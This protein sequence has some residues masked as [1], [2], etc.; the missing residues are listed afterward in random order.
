M[1]LTLTVFLQL[2]TAELPPDD[3]MVGEARNAQ[4]RFERLRR[5]LLPLK[6][7]RSAAGHCDAIMGRI[8]YWYDSTDVA[9]EP[10]HPRVTAARRELLATLERVAPADSVDGWV[11]GQQI[12]YLLETG[13]WETAARVAERDCDAARWW[14]AA[15][16]GTALHVGQRYERAD[17]AFNSALREMSAHQKCEWTDLR[18]IANRDLA[19][20]LESE[21]CDD[22]TAFVSTLWKLGQP[23][24]LVSGNDLRSEHFTRHTMAAVFRESAMPSDM[25]FGKDWREYVLRYGWSEWYTRHEPPTSA[26]VRYEYTGHSRSPSYYFLPDVAT[27]A[28]ALTLASLEWRLT[29]SLPR[30]RYAPRHA[31]RISGLPY[32]LARFPHGDSVLLI[33]AF[34]VSDTI[35]ARDSVRAGVAIWRPGR[36]AS[37]HA[38][39]S[40]RVTARV[41]ADTAVVSIEVLG[42]KTLRAQRARLPIAPLECAPSWCLSDILFVEPQ[43]VDSAPDPDVAAATALGSPQLQLGQPLGVYWELHTG[44]RPGPVDVTLTVTPVR[45]SRWRRVAS[46]LRLAR[47]ATPVRL[48]WATVPRR[49]REAQQVILRLPEDL[50]GRFRV[51]LAISRA[52]QEPLSVQ[53]E[54]SVVR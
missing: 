18:I 41:A 40:Q 17:S 8:C 46:S 15:L 32:Q 45:V 2:A 44:E 29:D 22:D 11:V 39:A 5:S 48:Q 20:A 10:E 37:V 24:W 33:A 51:S 30:S 28:S 54:I 36:S 34:D 47:P 25:S 35:L 14:C 53:R 13:D 7:H 9:V 52:G 6:P 42:R 26:Y 16:L 4:A 49:S 31:K 19:K 1:L 43:A 3:R 27:S 21:R 50:R 38:I 23:L 12:R